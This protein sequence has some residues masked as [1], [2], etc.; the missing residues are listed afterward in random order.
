MILYWGGSLLIK[1]V[2]VTFLVDNGDLESG[3][4]SFGKRGV[5]MSWGTGFG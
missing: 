1:A 4:G 3:V 2:S 5:H